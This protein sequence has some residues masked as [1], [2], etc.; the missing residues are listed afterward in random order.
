MRCTL[1]QV[2]GKNN[3]VRCISEKIKILYYGSFGFDEIFWFINIYFQHEIEWLLFYIFTQSFEIQIFYSLMRL[4][5]LFIQPLQIWTEEKYLFG[6]VTRLSRL[7]CIT[8]GT[9]GW[10]PKNPQVPD[11]P[12]ISFMFYVQL[13]LILKILEFSPLV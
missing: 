3:K 2:E 5:R 4:T 13:R 8:G 9:K 12:F 7:V 6:W 10:P 1:V 11:Q